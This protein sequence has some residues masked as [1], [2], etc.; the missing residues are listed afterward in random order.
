VDN[1]FNMG[2]YL[3]FKTL[4]LNS[5]KSSPPSRL[6]RVYVSINKP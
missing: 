3:L 4:A 1:T 5:T 6:S 2:H